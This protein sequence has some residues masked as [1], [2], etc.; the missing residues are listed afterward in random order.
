LILHCLKKDPHSRPLSIGEVEDRLQRI[1]LRLQQEAVSPMVSLG[2]IR[3]ERRAWLAL[4]AGVVLLGATVA[5]VGRSHSSTT[6][7]APAT[8]SGGAQRATEGSSGLVTHPSVR[9]TFD[10]DPPGATV[11][12]ERATQPV[13]VTPFSA[14]LDGSSRS[15]AFEFQLDGRPVV[16]QNLILSKDMGIKVTLP[17][18]Q[19]GAGVSSGESAQAQK[20]RGKRADQA[21]DVK[22]EPGALDHGVVLDPFE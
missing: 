18:A 16:R 19:P 22:A 15:E 10:S 11:F 20:R 7:P 4:G 9:V 14:T 5:L 8:E 12:R 3:P 13:G 17:T 6:A 1:A 2:P 21:V